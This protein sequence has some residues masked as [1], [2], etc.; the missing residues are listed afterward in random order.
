MPRKEKK[1][2]RLSGTIKDLPLREYHED[3]KAD[4]KGGAM[5]SAATTTEV[6]SPRDPASGL[7]TGKR[8]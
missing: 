2:P 3:E 4:V 6:V 5:K 8:N 1:P 7:P